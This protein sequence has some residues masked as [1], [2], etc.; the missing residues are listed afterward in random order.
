[1][2]YVG[3]ELDLFS[4]AKN[5]TAYFSSR[6]SPF[7]GRRILEVGAGIGRNIS[8]LHNDTVETWIGLEPDLELAAR[9]D[10][11]IHKG[12]FPKTCRVFV[13]TLSHIPPDWQFDTI[14]YIDVLEHIDDDAVELTRA[15]RH[16][17]RGGHLIVLAP[18]H[19]FLFSPF[20]SAIGHYRRY[21]GF[22]LRSIS[23]K[24]CVIK[25]LFMLDSVGFLASLANRL[26]L[27]KSI[28]SK[29]QIAFWD[30][31]LVPVSR[32]IDPVTRFKIGKTIVAVWS[33]Q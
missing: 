32:L 8:F 6:L 24:D 29:S 23:P 14:L 2:K 19:S 4:R 33:R 25:A 10:E 11:E 20:D 26:V 31:V 15:S 17:V 5:W 13:G 22:S 30:G 1:M 12:A 9:L 21:N 7:I 27:R 18:A 28:P 16:L 3:R